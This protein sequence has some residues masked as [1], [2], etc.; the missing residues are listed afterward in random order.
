MPPG[1][2]RIATPR[3][4]VV[5]I[6]D[7]GEH[8]VAEHEVGPPPLASQ[9]LGELDSEELD[10]RRDAALLGG[11]RD[12]RRRVDPEHGNALR[13][14]V[15]QQV[16]VVRGELDDEA[17]GAELEALTDHVDVDAR[18]LD[19][20]VRVR[21]EVGVLLEDLVRRDEGRKLREPASRADA[22]VERIERLDRLEPFGGEEA[23]AER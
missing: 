22:N 12:V 8:V 21:R 16:A 18:V 19:P 5:E 9:P 11:T 17:V 1:A 2:S 7:L 4:E 14:E 15:L 3:D 20:R 10:E 23:L 13:H 6:R